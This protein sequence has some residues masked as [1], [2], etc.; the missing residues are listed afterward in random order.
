MTKHTDVLKQKQASIE[1]NE[2]YLMSWRTHS[3]DRPHWLPARSPAVWKT[4]KPIRDTVGVTVRGPIELSRIPGI[5]ANPMTISIRLEIM[6]APWI[7]KELTHTQIR[8]KDLW[9]HWWMFQSLDIGHAPLAFVVAKYEKCWEEETNLRKSPLW[10]PKPR[11]SINL[12]TD[13]TCTMR[14]V[15]RF[16]LDN[17]FQIEEELICTKCKSV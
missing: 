6:I 2:M 7:Y 15:N 14:N 1:L 8:T 9:R 10:N 17:T 13:L 5:P 12:D 11:L 3:R 16:S 4:D